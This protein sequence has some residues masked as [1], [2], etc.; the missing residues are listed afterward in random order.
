LSAGSVSTAERDTPQEAAMK[1]ALRLDQVAQGREL[2]AQTL[3]SQAGITPEVATSLLAGEPA[4]IELSTLSRL[5]ELLGVLPNELVA[6]VEEP[7]ES[8]TEG[9]EPPRSID[10]PRQDMDE[11]KKERTDQY[12]PESP[13]ERLTDDA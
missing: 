3:A 13:S 12:D 1:V 4:E 11:I 10:V 6:E 2:D 7:Q 8:V 9:A 5:S